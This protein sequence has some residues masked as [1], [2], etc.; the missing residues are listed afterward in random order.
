MSGRLAIVVLLCLG[1]GACVGSARGADGEPCFEDGTCDG[2]T[3]CLDREGTRTCVHFGAVGEPCSESGAC[4]ADL[5]CQD[6]T[7]SCVTAACLDDVDCPASNC[8]EWGDCRFDAECATEGY[9]GRTC[10]DR[11]CDSGATFTCGWHVYDQRSD[12]GSAGAGAPPCPRP[13]DGQPCA[14]GT[15][16]CSGGTCRTLCGNGNR[17]PGEDCET[18]GECG[19]G[20]TCSGACRCVPL[21]PA[22]Q[23]CSPV[24]V[25]TKVVGSVCT[26]DGGAPAGAAEC[27]EGWECGVTGSCIAFDAG[28]RCVERCGHC[29][30]DSPCTVIQ[31]DAACLQDFDS[32]VAGT[33]AD[34]PCPEGTSCW[35]TKA[36]TR[37]CLRSCTYVP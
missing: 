1:A 18:A 5:G 15:G 32:E 2:K 25:D 24:T 29:P 20:E 37:R 26:V 35:T 12:S 16:S 17:D 11:R 30:V 33:C 31:G 21:C 34:H 4:D 3:R 22:G 10:R 9:R 13:T 6:S 28:R 7:D 8:D 14:D 36:G 19:G 27:T 23:E